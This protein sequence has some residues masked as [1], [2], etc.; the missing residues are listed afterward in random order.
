MGST[1]HYGLTRL[2]QG[3]N[4]QQDG[5]KYTNEDRAL[6]DRLLYLGAE[7]H[8]HT[9]AAGL[10]ETPGALGLTLGSS[11]GSLPAG[12]RIYYKHTLVDADGFE[13]SPST[14]VFVDTPAP[15]PEPS[16]AQLSVSTTG[17]SLLPGQ[18]FYVLTAHTAVNTDE[19]KALHPNYVTVP[20][21]T[22]T[23]RITLTLPSRPAGATGFN[24]YRKKPGSGRYDFLASTTSTGTYV[25]DGSV[26]EDC[27]R[28]V[29]TRNSTNS[30][31]SVTANI[32]TV[33]VGYTW[34]LYRTLVAGFYDSALLHHVVEET[35]EGS[36]IITGSYLDL[37]LG[38][39][40]GKPPATGQIVASPSKVDLEDGAEVQGRLPMGL[41]SAFP[42]VATFRFPGPVE[43][44][45]G[46]ELYVIEFPQAT[47]IGVRAALGRDFFPA[48]ANVI[49]DVELYRA[50]ATPVWGTIFTDQATR[51]KVLVGEMIGAR[52]TPQVTE[53][54]AGDALT[55]NVEQIGGGATPTDEDLTVSILMYAYGWGL[56]SHPWAD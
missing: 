27:N 51:P 42:V 28:V 41:V 40:P 24:I 35:S 39:L 38:T 15:L 53:L 4:F 52:A 44:V 21:G 50:G 30:T 46:T 26:E 32:G 18:Y 47:I 56:V 54:V 33:P 49:V 23:N 48:A 6:I 1:D 25:D 43:L 8:R 22:S 20:V 12:S 37:G 11:A 31:N 17:G 16:A 13:S 36:G 10:P 3:E 29:P 45:N 5:W 19:T 34:K 14:E 2:V 55:V 7:A 9:G